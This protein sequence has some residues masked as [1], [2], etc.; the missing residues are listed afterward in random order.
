MDF[1]SHPANDSPSNQFACIISG[2]GLS[3]PIA[4]YLAKRLAQIGIPTARV[5]SIKYFWNKRSPKRMS[6]DL[7]RYMTSRLK[8]KPDATFIFIGY[9]FGA[10]TLPFALNH[11]PIRFRDKITSVILIAPPARADFEFFFKSWFHKASDVAKPVA[12]EIQKLCE[13][14]PVLYLH[15]VADYIGPRLD[16]SPNENFRI[17]ALDGGHTFNKN[18]APLFDTI[19]A[20]IL[21]GVSGSPTCPLTNPLPARAGS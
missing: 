9:S 2:D 4:H 10:G 1:I 17:I 3:N 13:T 19:Q 11:L 14:I 5:K 15:G 18:Y 21:R 8:N 12:P 20:E 6:R 7:R 16:I